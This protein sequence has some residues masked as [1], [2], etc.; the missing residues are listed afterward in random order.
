MRCWT[1]GSF[2]V[3]SDCIILALLI[4]IARIHAPPLHPDVVHAAPSS[5]MP[6]SFQTQDDQSS[7]QD[8]TYCL[9][10]LTVTNSDLIAILD[11]DV[12]SPCT[13]LAN[14]DGLSGFR[15]D[16]RKFSGCRLKSLS[17]AEVALHLG[18]RVVA[19]PTWPSMSSPI[20]C[21]LSLQVWNMSDRMANRT[22]VA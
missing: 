13:L 9:A 15:F 6:P 14:N 10:Y 18:Y 16:C 11:G 22:K 2:A 12:I 8:L 7:R 21:I 3:V 1:I 5:K 17:S 20:T 4:P 19:R